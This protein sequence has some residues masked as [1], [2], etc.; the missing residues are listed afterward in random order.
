MRS[1][2][3]F[4]LLSQVLAQH[5]ASAFGAF[6][7]GGAGSFRSIRF[8]VGVDIDVAVASSTTSRNPNRRSSSHLQATTTTQEQDDSS[9]MSEFKEWCTRKGIITPLDLQIRSTSASTSTSTSTLQQDKDQYRYMNYSQNGT[10]FS[11][12]S[13]RPEKLN[14]PILR[15]PLNACIIAETLEELTQELVKERDL[16][17]ASEFAAYINVLP[18]L[19]PESSSSSSFMTMPRFWSDAKIDK[20]S[21]YDGGQLYQK[22]QTDL[23]EAQNSNANLDPWAHACVTSRANYL[24]DVGYAMTPV[25]DMFNHDSSSQT[26]ASIIDNELFLSVEKEFEMGEE[27]FISYGDLSNLE[28]LVNYG[29]VVSAAAA[30]AA[31]AD[32]NN[33]FNREYVDVRMI[34]RAPVR[35]IIDQHG[36]LDAGS[37]AALRSYLTPAEEVDA[38]LAKDENLSINTVFAKPLSDAN[39]EEV[40]SFIAS[41]VDEAIYDGKN[42]IEW[43]KESGEGDDL[44]ERYLAARVVVLEKGLALMKGKF[45]DLLY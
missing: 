2:K 19:N 16:G 43:A 40:Y 18:K 45:A 26:S 20:I 31:A 42:G 39:E 24:L 30:A 34:R 25:L 15:V 4:F 1:I 11:I 32:K 14:G 17:S 36:S 5:Q 7:S 35:V 41:F 21:E 38:L 29:F 27:V 22:L 28:T 10:S 44:V 9:T 12:N 13:S 23:K 33:E 37:L 6:Q 3:V 8:D